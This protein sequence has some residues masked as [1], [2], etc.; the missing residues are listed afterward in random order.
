MVPVGY[1]LLAWLL[2]YILVR[3]VIFHLSRDGEGIHVIKHRLK[4]NTVTGQETDSQEKNVSV[5]KKNEWSSGRLVWGELWSRDNNMFVSQ[6]GK[7]NKPHPVHTANIMSLEKCF[8]LI[9]LTW[10]WRLE[11]SVKCSLQPPKLLLLRYVTRSH[12]FEFCTDFNC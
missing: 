4:R 1:S 2:G 6:T 9:Y 10:N 12:N 7:S 5:K 11:V 3:R 8:D